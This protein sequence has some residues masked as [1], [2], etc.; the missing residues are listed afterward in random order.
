MA[1][2]DEANKRQSVIKRTFMA[3]KFL[4]PQN[5]DFVVDSLDFVDEIRDF[6]Y[7]MSLCHLRLHE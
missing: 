4:T 7:N 5:S 3:I 6:V 1:P 2:T